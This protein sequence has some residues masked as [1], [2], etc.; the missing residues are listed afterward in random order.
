M[1]AIG[2]IVLEFELPGVD[3]VVSYSTAIRLNLRLRLVF[4]LHKKNDILLNSFIA[5]KR[6]NELPRRTEILI[7]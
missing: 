5:Q 3:G 2:N 7:Q 4:G 1:P 6:F